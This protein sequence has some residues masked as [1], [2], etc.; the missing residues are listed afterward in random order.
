[1]A[2]STP[3]TAVSNTA[4]TAAQWNA[5]VRDDLLTTAPALATTAGSHFVGTGV[6]AIAERISNTITVATS[7][8]TSTTTYT[9]LTTVGPQVPITTGTKAIGLWSSTSGNNTS[10]QNSFMSV[11]VSGA[12]PTQVGQDAYS[13]RFQSFGTNARHRASCVHMWTGLTSGSNTFTAVYKVDA[14]I[15]TWLDRE[16]IIIPL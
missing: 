14:G 13:L 2:W 7:E 3:L 9:N 5:S 16:L 8:T 4:L 1:M 15:G 6:N 12:T 11:S 10:G